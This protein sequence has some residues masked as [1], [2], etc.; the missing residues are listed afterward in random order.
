MDQNVQA[1]QGHSKHH[2]DLTGVSFKTGTPPSH[3]AS[4][5]H[6]TTMTNHDDAL[7][8]VDDDGGP[9]DRGDVGFG[10]RRVQRNPR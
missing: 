9:T 8:C 7:T 10:I 4:P 3:G 1:I 5:P 2:H 6:A